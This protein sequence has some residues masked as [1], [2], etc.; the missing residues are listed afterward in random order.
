MKV[1]CIQPKIDENIDKCFSQ[2]ESLL[3]EILNKFEDCEIVC[4]PERWVPILNNL[5]LNIQKERGENY[6]FLKDLA[7][8]YNINILSGGIWES[9]S[10]LKKPI[11]TCY[12]L[13]EKGEEIGRQDKI[14]LYSYERK[15]FEAGKEL[16]IFSLNNYHFA[17][18]I[19]FDM[20]FFE[21]PRLAVE[22]GADILLSPTQ[23]RAD[24]MENWKIYLQARVLENRTPAAASN[25][26]GSFF[27][28]TFLGHS[29]IISFVNGYISPSKL[30]LN[31]GP[32][33]EGGYVFDDI[34]LEFPK[35]LR[36][37]RLNE[38][39]D[40]SKITIKKI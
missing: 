34:D 24:G 33:G 36:K 29:K 4:L 22:N 14:H 15:Q 9:R 39:I 1:A 37:I 17:I 6:S 25:T 20:A 19:C 7:K 13:N 40:K 8:N 12:Y 2:I 38:I 27:N 21:T 11:I 5:S 23:I 32:F 28:R 26:C 16:K 31:E 10:N 35:K 18:L 30:K 3:K